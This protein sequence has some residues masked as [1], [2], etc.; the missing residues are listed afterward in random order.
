MAATAISEQVVNGPYVLETGTQFTTLT[1]TASDP[2][3]MNKVVMSTGRA[4]VIFHNSDGANPY[5]ATVYSSKDAYGRTADVT[6]FSLAAN[7]W[8]ARVFEG[9]GWEQT[10]GGRDLLIDTENVAVKIT[11]IPL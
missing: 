10:T 2:T 7:A 11:A 9:P 5:W 3:N 4:L 1:E 6:Q 8:A